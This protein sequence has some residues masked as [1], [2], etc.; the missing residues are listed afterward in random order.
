[1]PTLEAAAESAQERFASLGAMRA[2]HAELLEKVPDQN[3]KP[4]DI[5]RVKAFLKK[6][7]ATGAL[8]DNP[9]DRKA[10][11]GLLDYWR[12]TLYAESRGGSPEQLAA[13]QAGQRLTDAVLASFDQQ[14]VRGVAEAAEGAISTF[15]SAELTRRLLLR[16][17]RL[18]PNARAFEPDPADRATLEQLGDPERVRETLDQLTRAGV[19]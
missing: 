6:G 14:T 3:L 12:A 10:A 2:A 7:A 13:T 15:P 8:L 18:T 4:E 1:M 19:L 16:L 9:A 5:D 17:V 11:Q